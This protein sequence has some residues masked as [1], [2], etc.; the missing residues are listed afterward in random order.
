MGTGIRLMDITDGMAATGPGRH[1]QEPAGWAPAMIGMSFT[2]ATGRGIAD[3]SIT[4][5]DGIASETVITGMIGTAIEI[6]IEI[7]ANSYLAAT[8]GTDFTKE[9]MQTFSV[10]SVQ[11]VV[12]YCQPPPRAL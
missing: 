7:A 4:T 5:T 1:M 2:T 6:T 8:D 3:G 11:S 9:Q 12:I 10:K